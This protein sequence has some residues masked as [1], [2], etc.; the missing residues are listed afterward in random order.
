MEKIQMTT[1]L[2]EMDGDEMTRV[3]WQ[4]I[5]DKLILPYV[6]LKTIYFDLGLGHRDA[7]DDEVTFA[8]A[9]AIKQYGVGVKCATITPNAER[10]EEYKHKDK[11]KRTNGPIRALF[12]LVKNQ[13]LLPVMPMGMST[14]M[15]KSMSLIKLRQN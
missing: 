6:D 3:L 1:P 8:A 4:M 13:S 12:A 14:A 11:Y 9:E 7:T 2:V 10:V 5:K 15:Q